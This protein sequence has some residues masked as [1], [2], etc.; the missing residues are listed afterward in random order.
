[1]RGELQGL[2]RGA[3]LAVA[4]RAG[5]LLGEPR[6]ECTG[7]RDI[8]GLGADRI[9]TAEDDIVDCSAVEAN[10]LDEAADGMGTEIG[11][12]RAT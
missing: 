1:M 2:L 8:P 9:D 10:P 4:S 6:Y 3:A 7:P 5:H 11:R 12:M